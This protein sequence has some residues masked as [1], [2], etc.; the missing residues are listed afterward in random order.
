M[1]AKP[2]FEIKENEEMYV[3]IVKKQIKSSESDH[4]LSIAPIIN[5]N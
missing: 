2:L 1:I 4:L 5:K 3:L